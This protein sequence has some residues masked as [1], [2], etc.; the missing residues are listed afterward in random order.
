MNFQNGLPRIWGN[1]LHDVFRKFSEK[2][3]GILN[4]VATFAAEK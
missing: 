3:L 2:S 1:I 4:I